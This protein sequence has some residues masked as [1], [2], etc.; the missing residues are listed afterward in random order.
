MYAVG[1]S[2]IDRP[3]IRHRHGRRAEHSDMHAILFEI[4]VCENKAK[5]TLQSLQI[6]FPV[7]H[8]SLETVKSTGA[9]TWSSGKHQ[10]STWTCSASC[11]SSKCNSPNQPHIDIGKKLAGIHQTKPTKSSHITRYYRKITLTKI[12]ANTGKVRIFVHVSTAFY[13]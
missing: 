3:M 8:F 12:R 9:S 11:Q 7:I 13:G 4:W 10:T 6:M 5:V 2:S 1:R